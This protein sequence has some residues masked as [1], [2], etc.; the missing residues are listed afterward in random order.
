MFRK[1]FVLLILLVPFIA[2]GQDPNDCSNAL[3]VCGNTNLSF[4]SAGPGND[5]FAPI[6]NPQPGCGVQE[7]QSLWLRVPIASD[8]TLG[9]NIT[10]NNNDDFDFAVFGPNVDCNALGD[11]IRCSFASTASGFQTGLNSSATDNSEDG[12]GDGFVAELQVQAGDVYT[13]LIDNFSNS[14]R[15]FDLVWTGTAQIVDAPPLN[16]IPDQEICDVNNDGT[17]DFDLSTLDLLVSGGS[18]TV[19]VS[20]HLNDADATLG[21]NPLPTIYSAS[22]GDEIFARATSTSDGCASIGSF[23]LNFSPRPEGLEII[24]PSSVCP[25]VDNVVYTIPNGPGNTYIWS[26]NGGT[27]VSGGNTDQIEV[28]W[29][30]ANPNAFLEAIPTNAANCEGDVIRLDVT[31]NTRLEPA[32]PTGPLLVC[33]SD[34]TLG[35]YSVPNSNGSTYEWFVSNGTFVGSNNTNEV[36]IRWNGD[37]PGMVW[38]REFNPSIANCE[39]TSPMQTVNFFPQVFVI[40]SQ[41]DVSCAG[42]NTG[43]IELSITGGLGPFTVLWDDGNTDENRIGLIAGDYTYTVTDANMCQV[44]ETITITEPLLLSI[45][46]IMATNLLCFEDNSG[47]A[48]ATVSG[49]TAPYQYDWRRNGNSVDNSPTVANNLAAGNYELILTDANNCT[50][51]R[52]FRLTEPTLLQPDLDQLLNNPICPQATDG[53]VTVGAR[54]GTPDYSFVWELV[55]QQTGPIATGLS[56]GT[57]RVI[58]SDMNGCTTS[59][60]VEVVER[61]PR[62]VIPSAFS[63]N[64]DMVNDTFSPVATCSLDQFKMVIYDRWGKPLFSSDQVDNGWDGSFEGKE[65]GLGKYTYLVNYQFNVN[66]QV[67]NES[68]RGSVSIVR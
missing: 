28:N 4:N 37:S 46:D 14:N 57:Y 66:G 17:E 58:I 52:T 9:F 29:G 59:Q 11:A 61:F 48:Q 60:T 40:T 51:S 35:T 8:G 62:I 6:D 63:P 5:D 19:I 7:N 13:I 42:E 27:I 24:G 3:I 64:S 67:F 10:P 56:R 21:N 31:I 41:T 32:I 54:G 47:I 20:Y 55:P 15:G 30:S 34:N 2:R 50:A 12:G 1:I 16:T 22:N 45:D 25:D 18:P 39:G 33:I 49:G 26:A 43:S 53:E 44:S 65:V 68:I 38:F 36:T 23:L